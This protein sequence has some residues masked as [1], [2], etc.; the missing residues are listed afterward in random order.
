MSDARRWSNPVPLEEFLGR[1]DSRVAPIGA[2]NAEA[3]R[4]FLED[5]ATGFH[6]ERHPAEQPSL[7]YNR[8]MSHVRVVCAP[9]RG[10][11]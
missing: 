1:M 5:L 2:G 8:D 4:A 7:E 9:C 6:C 3:M 10:T 11:S